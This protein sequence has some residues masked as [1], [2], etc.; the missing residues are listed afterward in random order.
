MDPAH[1][2]FEVAKLLLDRG[3]DPNACIIKEYY[4]TLRFTALTGVFGGGDTGTANQPPHPRCRELAELLLE[5]GTDPADATAV[6]ITQGRELTY[7]K[8]EILLRHGLRS[9]AYTTHPKADNRT[10]TITLMGLALAL[11]VHMRDTDSVKLLLART[12]RTDELFGGKTR[13]QQAMERG[14][15]E[16]ARLLEQAGAPTVVLSDLERF[17]S[18]CLAGDEP[19]VRTI[20]EDSPGLPERAPKNMVQRAVGTGRIAAVNLVLDLGFDPNWV[21]ENA[22]IHAA[23]ILAGN[24]EILRLLLAR[25]AD[26]TLRDPSYDS[27]GVGWADFFDYSLL[28]DKLLDEGAICLFD[29]LDYDRLDRVAGVLARDPTSLERPLAKCLSR[30]PKPEDWQTPLVRM[31]NRGQAGAVRVL[32]EHGADITASHPS[33]QSVL[34]LAREKGFREIAGLLERRG[35]T[36]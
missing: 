9:D 20:L 3:A 32:L 31:V 4:G 33:G 28:R 21:G 26:L 1:S 5:R 10:G 35:A 8:L 17:V 22:A 23:G 25:G 24:E 13:W 36:R 12:A 18:L 14:D 16:I 6:K 15:F 2:T 34:D 7:G 27:T 29:A 19:G 30:D 11:A